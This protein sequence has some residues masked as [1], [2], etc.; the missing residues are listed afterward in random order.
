MDVGNAD[1]GQNMRLSQ[2]QNFQNHVALRESPGQCQLRFLAAE[3]CCSLMLGLGGP[4]LHSRTSASSSASMWHC[5]F[6]LI[7]KPG[8]RWPGLVSAQCLLP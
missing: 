2:Q 6:P 5:C 8:R 4:R 1:A 3:M 7:C